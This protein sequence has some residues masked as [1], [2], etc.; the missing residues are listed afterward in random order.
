MTPD[1]VGLDFSEADLDALLDGDVGFD[2]FD[3]AFRSEVLGSG[4][5]DLARGIAGQY[6][7]VMAGF[8]AQAF[9]GTPSR[10]QA[11]QVAGAVT[12]LRRLAVEVE[13]SKLIDVLDQL[14]PLV[15]D[16]LKGVGTRRT[17]VVRLRKWVDAMSDVLPE[18]PARRMSELIHYDRGRQPLLSELGRLP[19]IGRRRLQRLY[20]AGLFTVEAIRSAS[21]AT[22]ISQ[23]TGVPEPLCEGIFLATER[24]ADS[25]RERCVREIGQ[26]A[27][28]LGDW[29]GGMEPDDP[30]RIQ[31]LRATQEALWSLE[32]AL[33]RA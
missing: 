8:A 5:H 2:D 11:E 23:V 31:A 15:E 6:V 18:E 12:S 29:L 7:V 20:A 4:L 10:D 27:K 33:T 30:R 24:F 28:E 17:R 22:E 32:A 9:R 14:P 26:R 21:S 16:W 19:G 1:A 25:E 3:D 13:D